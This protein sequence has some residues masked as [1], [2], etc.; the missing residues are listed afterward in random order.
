MRFVEAEIRGTEETEEEEKDSAS[1]RTDLLV[2]RPR[3]HGGKR[4]ESS[5]T[6]SRP[7]LQK[8]DVEEAMDELRESGVW[9]P[10]L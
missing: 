10:G 8:R 1:N 7:L 6:N 5:P 4:K 3:I 9:R 2:L